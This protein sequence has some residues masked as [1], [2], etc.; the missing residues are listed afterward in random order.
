[1]NDV[2]T[3]HAGDGAELSVLIFGEARDARVKMTPLFDGPIH[4]A[5]MAQPNLIAYRDRCM[6]K[7]YPDFKT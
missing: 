7:W 2:D 4:Q 3:A 1:M 6:A 5:A